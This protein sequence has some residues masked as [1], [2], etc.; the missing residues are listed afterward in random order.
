MKVVYGE[1]CG[2]STGWCWAACVCDGK[3]EQVSINL[4]EKEWSG[5][6][7]TATDATHLKHWES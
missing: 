3:P 5:S 7:K 6:P 2:V 4:N 1:E